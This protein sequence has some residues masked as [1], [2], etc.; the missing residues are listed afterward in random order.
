MRGGRDEGEGEEKRENSSHRSPAAKNIEYR[1][2]TTWRVRCVERSKLWERA[3]KHHEQAL[4]RGCLEM[5]KAHHTEWKKHWIAL[6]N[7]HTQLERH[8]LRR[9]HAQ[10]VL[11]TRIRAMRRSVLLR[12]AHTLLSSTFSSWRGYVRMRENISNTQKS[13]VE[14][15]NLSMLR[16]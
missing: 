8:V 1:A 12:A 6:L 13:V 3:R 11:R 9:W 4:L 7:H 2:F 5:W 10:V 16:R 14:Y 15:T